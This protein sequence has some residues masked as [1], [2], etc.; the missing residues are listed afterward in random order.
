MITVQTT[1]QLRVPDEL[2]GRVMGIYGITHNVGPLGALQ[3][4]YIAD[5]WSPPAALIVGGVAI[6]VFAVGIAY[7]NRSV[8]TLQGAPAAA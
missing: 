5:R 3:A 6:I 7:S 4:G 2:R 8:R 1:L